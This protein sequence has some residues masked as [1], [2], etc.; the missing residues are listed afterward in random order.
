M[1][2]QK[3]VLRGFNALLTILRKLKRSPD[4]SANTLLLINN[5][6]RSGKKS[7]DKL[8]AHL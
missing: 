6:I 7:L 1:K 8:L 3:S 5:G 4:A 2:K